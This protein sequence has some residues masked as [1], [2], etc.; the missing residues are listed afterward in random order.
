MLVSSSKASFG[1]VSSSLNWIII[2]SEIF[3]VLT[4]VLWKVTSSRKWRVVVWH[5]LYR[6]FARMYWLLLQ[7]WSVSPPSEQVS[8]TQQTC[9]FGLFSYP[10]DGSST[11]LR[12]VGELLPAYRGPQP[13]GQYSSVSAMFVITYYR[14]NSF[15]AK[16]EARVSVNHYYSKWFF[17]NFETSWNVYL[18]TYISIV[19][20]IFA[21]T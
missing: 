11:F 15:E 2:Y 10:E 1:Y 20:F 4:A 5:K 3:Q 12:R 17:L 19:F 14:T 7:G 16:A 9:L 8:S 13:R 6:C 21:G 18:R